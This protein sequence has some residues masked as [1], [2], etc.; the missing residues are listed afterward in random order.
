MPL[1][2]RVAGNRQLKVGGLVLAALLVA[3]LAVFFIGKDDRLFGRKASYFVRFETVS[4]LAEGSPVQLDGVVVGNV[5]DVNLPT[6]MKQHEITVW[7]AIDR[8]YAGRI[9]GDS[10]AKIKTL[11][12]LGDRYIAVNSGSP[13]FP[14]IAIGGEIPTAAQTSVDQLI[15]SGEDVMQN[16]VQISHSLSSILD[17]MDKG[18]GLLGKLTT[19]SEEGNAL[20]KSLQS[21]ADS[22]KGIA[23]K[24]ENGKG[25]LGR[26]IEDKAL[27]DQFAQAIARLNGTLGRFETGQGALPALLDD[28]ATK[29]KLDSTLDGLAKATQSLSAVA[30]DLRSGDGLLPK[31]I[32]DPEYGRKVSGELQQL[33]ERLNLVSTRLTEGD[34]TAAKLINDPE[35]YA[36]VKDILVGVNESR[37][38]RWLVR[39]RQQKG[40]EKRYQEER[41]KQGQDPDTPPPGP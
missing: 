38:L 25:P 40:I 19:D 1:D 36:A 23:D 30:D 28:P 34:G 33:I 13:E 22:V 41:R 5:R 3:A 6:D 20:G 24:I 14:A 27:G 17:R 12:L 26:L 39:S 31:L 32:H 21:T 16:V 11:G 4:G 9:R 7:L 2:P 8:R 37:F 35:V 10:A 15:S 18:Q 29:A